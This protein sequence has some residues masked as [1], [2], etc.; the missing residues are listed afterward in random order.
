MLD[1]A[2]PKLEGPLHILMSV[3]D[4]VKLQY[5]LHVLLALWILHIAEGSYELN[6]ATSS[7]S[8]EFEYN[9]SAEIL[10][11]REWNGER[12]FE[13]PESTALCRLSSTLVI[14][15]SKGSI[16]TTCVNLFCWY[17]FFPEVTLRWSGIKSYFIVSAISNT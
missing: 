10:I 7:V 4:F 9:N 13:F 16:V 17:V 15:F 3:F 6:G 2:I 8:S 12:L 5:W 14:T 1:P 11:L